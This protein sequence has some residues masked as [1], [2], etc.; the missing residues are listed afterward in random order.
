MCKARFLI[1]IIFFLVSGPHISLGQFAPDI[2]W[3]TAIGGNGYDCLRSLQQTTDGGFILGGYSTSDIGQDKSQPSYG[4][5]YSR[6]YWV[7]KVDAN[8]NKP[9]IKPSAEQTA[10]NSILCNKPP[11]AA[12]FS[13]A[14]LIR[15]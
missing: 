9:G 1:F 6:D 12:I 13:A 14:F 10:M 3:E 11:M 7:V 2:A 15:P 5:I 4:N 8:G